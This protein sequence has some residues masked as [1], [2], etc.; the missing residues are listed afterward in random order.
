MTHRDGEALALAG[1]L[2]TAGVTHLVRPG[3]YDPI[4]P[5]ALPG[6]A[7]FWTYA[8]GAAELAVAA[9]VAHPATRRRGGLAAAA[10][11][12]AVLPANV[13]MAWDWR[14]RRP[15]RRAIAYGRL[16]MQVPLIWWAL[17]VARS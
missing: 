6:P 10:L 3:L 9:A 16:P 8:S 14:R 11:F 17:R 15:A 12:V 2:A 4:V 1:L 7:R 13:Q 5:R